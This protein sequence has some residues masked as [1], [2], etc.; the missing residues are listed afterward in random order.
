[1]SH[2][3]SSEYATDDIFCTFCSKPAAF[4]AAMIE[5]PS[6]IFICEDC[7]AACAESVMYE[8]DVDLRS[9]KRGQ[10]V[11]TNRVERNQGMVVAST[12][13]ES[14]RFARPKGLPTPEEI[15]HR[16]CEHVVGQDEAKLSLSVAVYNHFARVLAK[17]SGLDSGI[18]L[19][20]SNVLVIGPTG[21]G[22][23][24]LAKTLAKTL[25]VPF[26]IADA[27]T[28]TEAGYGGEDVE[29]VLRMLI[30]AADGDVKRAE[31]GIVYIDEIDKI[32]SRNVGG[33]RS[34]SRD[35]SGEGVQQALLKLIEGTKA[36]VPKS[37]G[38]K[39]NDSDRYDIDT[40]N[41]LF[42][43]GGAFPGLEDIVASRSVGPTVGFNSN[44]CGVSG[45]DLGDL[46]SAVTPND[47]SDY[48]MLPEFVG[49]TPIIV[50]LDELGE[51]AL[52]SVQTEPANAIV[53]QYQAQFRMEGCDLTFTEEALRAMAGEAISLGT[54][55]RGLRS[56][57]ERVL[58]GAMFELPSHAGPTHVIVDKSD[59]LG[60]TRPLVA[61]GSALCASSDDGA[62]IATGL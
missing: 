6:G 55:V 19:E 62:C 39:K 4:S 38:P 53:R 49:R 57:Y 1:M 42:I 2:H 34:G 11:W 35:V 30:E 46:L 16:L 60:E 9:N 14:P 51:D 7:I 8:L 17:A 3:E 54:G 5:G 22:K 32:A 58:R 23:T 29:S 59:V 61:E 28:L 44:P 26:A 24:L 43:V 10:L 50:T 12:R 41:I 31:M 36:S 27:T 40:S 56:I 20:K 21:S 37:S 47:L 25:H 48:G 15:H 52:V 45:D 13:V 18:E 33:V